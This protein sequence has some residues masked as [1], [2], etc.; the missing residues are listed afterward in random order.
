MPRRVRAAVDSRSSALPSI[1]HAA[2][3]GASWPSITL[4]SVD[5][6]APFGS[7]Q[8]GDLAVVAA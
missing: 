5:L 8:R 7:D 1:P 4:K 2:G 3:V 6:P